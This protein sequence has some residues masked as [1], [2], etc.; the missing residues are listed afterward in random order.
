MITTLA[1]LR[2]NFARVIRRMNKDSKQIVTIRMEDI[3]N[4]NVVPSEHSFW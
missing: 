3:S 2:R 1:P 4:I